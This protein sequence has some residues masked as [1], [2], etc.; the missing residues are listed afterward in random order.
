MGVTKISNMKVNLG[1]VV[2]SYLNDAM[3]EITLSMKES[4]QQRI[5]FVKAL[6]FF[7][8]NLE[9]GVTDE[10]LDWLWNEVIVN[11]NCG[12]SFKHFQNK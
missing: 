1:T 11:G 6:T 12:N 9:K 8:E 7:N 5:R 3:L 4:A 2:A 10:Y